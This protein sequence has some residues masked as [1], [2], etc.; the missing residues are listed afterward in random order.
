MFDKIK[1][2]LGLEDPVNYN[3]LMA[4]GAKIIDVRTPSEYKRGHIKGSINI[5]LQELNKKHKKLNKNNTIITCCA[6]GARSAS[7]KG[8][9]ESNGFKEVYNGKG[10]MRLQSKLN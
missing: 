8:I 10:S 1:S 7:A 4:N 2:L 6:S 9:L 5:P 3:E